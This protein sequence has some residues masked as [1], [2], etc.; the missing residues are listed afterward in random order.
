M[1]E[2]VQSNGGEAKWWWGWKMDRLNRKKKIQKKNI[3]SNII[4]T[5]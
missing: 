1:R 3:G 5:G 2:L 4:L